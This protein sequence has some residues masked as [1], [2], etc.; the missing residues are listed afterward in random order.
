M[1]FLSA[2]RK[3]QGLTQSDLALLA[4]LDMNS[5]ARYERGEVQPSA[6]KAIAIAHALNVNVTELFNGSDSTLGA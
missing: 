6:Q 2:I 4:G 5:I 3:K 1:K